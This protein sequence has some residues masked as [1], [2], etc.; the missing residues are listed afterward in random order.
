MNTIHVSKHEYQ[1]LLELLERE[2][3]NLHKE[4]LHTDTYDYRQFLKERERSFIDLLH[5]LQAHKYCAWQPVL[6]VNHHRL[7]LNV[8]S[9]SREQQRRD[10]LWQ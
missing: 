4:I 9:W 7:S 2:V 1:L 5:H 6:S 10:S 3:L 8:I